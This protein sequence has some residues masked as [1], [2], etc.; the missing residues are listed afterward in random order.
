MIYRGRIKKWKVYRND[1][2]PYKTMAQVRAETGCDV[3]MPAFMYNTAAM[4]PAYNVKLDGIILHRDEYPD[5]SV[6]PYL[7]FA[8]NEGEL[9]VMTQNMNAKENFI[10]AVALVRGGE[11]VTPFNYPAALGGTRGRMAFGFDADGSFL[12]LCTT[13]SEG[14]MTMEELQAKAAALGYRDAMYPD[15][16]GSCCLLTPAG[17][18]PQTRNIFAFL[19]AWTEG[20]GTGTEETDGKT[21]KV[22][23]GIDVSEHQGEIDWPQAENEI[24]FA[25][26]RAGY[27]QNNID[28]QFV[29]NITECN[30]LGIPCGVYWFSYA[31]TEDMA[32]K[33]AAHCLAAVRPYKLQFPVAFDFEYDS[34]NNAAK[35]G[36]KVDRA[37]ATALCHA[38]CGAVEAAG[39]YALN[40]TN[41]DFL[42]NLFDETTTQK[43]D[44]WHAAWPENPDPDK[45]PGDC[46]IWQYSSRGKI[47]GVGGRVDL[48][49]AYRDYPALIAA[50]GLNN[51]APAESETQEDPCKAA[52]EKLIAAG[53]GDII[54]SLSEKL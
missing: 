18:V 52:C 17:A 36:V 25:M 37:L 41:T 43:Y 33:E 2:P 29:R 8:W 16:G 40:Y 10:S 27:G 23:R 32:R 9:P 26:I 39:Y 6:Y 51:L 12:A 28:R 3:V 47:A 15:G 20:A 31:R 7:G 13:D 48:D 45:P 53:W 35:N 5:G 44:L 11:A 1:K 21:K 30:R 54:L 38:F 49:A 46:G 19:C 4:V 34:V 50:A 24:G 14:P 22:I 42:Q